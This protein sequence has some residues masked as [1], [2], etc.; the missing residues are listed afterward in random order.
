MI[1]DEELL[2]ESSRRAIGADDLAARGDMERR[3]AAYARPESHRPVEALLTRVLRSAFSPER[4]CRRITGLGGHHRPL[5]QFKAL[6]DLPAK[7]GGRSRI[8]LS[9]MRGVLSPTT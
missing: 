2:T 5:I 8:S 9:G 4:D 6:H 3:G 7:D 1:I